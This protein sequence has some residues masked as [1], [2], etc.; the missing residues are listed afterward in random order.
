[1]PAREMAEVAAMPWKFS[2]S[3][4]DDGALRNEELGI[5]RFEFGKIG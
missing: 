1:M 4:A 3:A 5:G 2:F